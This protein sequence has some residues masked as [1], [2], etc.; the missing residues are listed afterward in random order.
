MFALLLLLR[1]LHACNK[2]VTM[3]RHPP[4]RYFFSF[5]LVSILSNFD[6]FAPYFFGA[7]CSPILIIRMRCA[8][9]INRT[10][11]HTCAP[12]YHLHYPFG[13]GWRLCAFFYHSID[14][15]ISYSVVTILL[16]LTQISG[17]SITSLRFQ[18]CNL[19]S[20]HLKC[21]KD[22]WCAQVANALLL[23]LK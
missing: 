10:H 7:I 8:H 21:C 14:C 4:H 11:L 23:V 18:Y 13:V 12:A 3:N 19:I 15:S 1:L 9:S 6:A 17:S 22:E 16:K 20:I 5:L 2:C